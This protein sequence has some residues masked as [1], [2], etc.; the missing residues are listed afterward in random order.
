MAF[1]AGVMLYVSLVE[2][3]AVSNEYFAKE[4]PPA[5]AYA[6][7]TASLFM[8]VVVMAAVDAA[9]HWVFDAVSGG[10]SGGRGGGRGKRGVTSSTDGAASGGGGAG[11]GGGGPLLGAQLDVEGACGAT[12]A[13]HTGRGAHVDG[14]EE[15]EEEEEDEEQDEEH[16]GCAIRSVGEIRERRRLLRMAAVVSAAIVLHNIPEGMVHPRGHF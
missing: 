9:V 8:G 15:Q 4:H 16:G 1:S 3:V 6:L 14:R 11:G 12:A 10:Q 5:R 2:V 7:A 13:D